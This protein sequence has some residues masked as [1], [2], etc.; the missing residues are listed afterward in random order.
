MKMSLK[1]VYFLLKKL[2]LFEI[3]VLDNYANSFISVNS[4]TT[5]NP[6]L[7]NSLQEENVKGLCVQLF[8]NFTFS[9]SSY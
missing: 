3:R 2:N 8:L 9:F 1:S 5:L 7:S 4:K 6:T